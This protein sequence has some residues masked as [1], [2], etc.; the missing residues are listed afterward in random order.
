M[1]RSASTLRVEYQFLTC[2]PHSIIRPCTGGVSHDLW[3]RKQTPWRAGAQDVDRRGQGLSRGSAEGFRGGGL[4]AEPA[5]P[6][7]HA[8]P[9]LTSHPSVALKSARGQ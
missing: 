6:Q 1:S 9:R 3:A 4:S 7:E 2:G 5:P 8:S